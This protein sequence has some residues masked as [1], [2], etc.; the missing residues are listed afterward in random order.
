MTIV[1]VQPRA[2]M[3]PPWL[4]DNVEG[5]QSTVATSE[6]TEGEPAVLNAHQDHRTPSCNGEESG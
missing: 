3:G 2:V 1:T 6:S 5:Q 4:R